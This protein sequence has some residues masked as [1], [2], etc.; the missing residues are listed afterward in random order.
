VQGATAQS[1]GAATH[2]TF[3]YD[4]DG[5]LLTPNF[6]DYHVPHALDMPPLKT[7]S[8]ESPSPF[9][10]LGAKGMGE[11]GGA[12]L[13]AVAAALQNALQAAGSPIITSSSNP[14]HRVWELM[15]SPDESRSLVS[16]DDR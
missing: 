10:P 4:E 9:T 6:Y 12:G 11:G 7:A 13:S 15:Q 1:I 3:V 14:Y 16:V 5:N 2:E 8:L